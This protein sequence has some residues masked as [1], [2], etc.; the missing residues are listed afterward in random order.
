MKG[1]EDSSR[2]TELVPKKFK[3]KKQQLVLLSLSVSNTRYSESY[4][5]NKNSGKT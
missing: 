4:K 2:E 5:K 1:R 3:K